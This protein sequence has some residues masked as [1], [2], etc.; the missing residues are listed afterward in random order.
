MNRKKNMPNGTPAKIID[1]IKDCMMWEIQG[2]F[3]ISGL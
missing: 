1:K 3:Q 2:S